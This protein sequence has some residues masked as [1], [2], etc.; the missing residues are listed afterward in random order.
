MGGGGWPPHLPW[1]Y[2]HTRLVQPEAMHN[3]AVPR[4]TGRRPPGT[5]EDPGANLL[6]LLVATDLMTCWTVHL[7]LQDLP[8]KQGPLTL[9]NRPAQPAPHTRG[10]LGV[11][12]C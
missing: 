7:N 11:S 6:R 1:L 2:L 5:Y 10:T 8:P 12:Q 9:T 4:L 3:H